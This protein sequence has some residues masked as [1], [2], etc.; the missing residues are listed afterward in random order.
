MK[1]SL[2][3]YSPH[4]RM[5]NAGIVGGGGQKRAADNLAPDETTCFIAMSYTNQ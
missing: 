3:T 5:C 4:A 2:C 1:T